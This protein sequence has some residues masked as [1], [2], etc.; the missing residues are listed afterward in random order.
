MAEVTIL[1]HDDGTFE[2]RAST[3]SGHGVIGHRMLKGADAKFPS[4]W[5]GLTIEEALKNQK[6]W[7]AFLDKQEGRLGR[8]KKK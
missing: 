4:E 8:G 1:P 2:L 6:L 3:Y 5:K 7:T